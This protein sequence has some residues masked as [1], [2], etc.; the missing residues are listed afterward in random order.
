MFSSKRA[1]KYT[2]GLINTRNDC[3]A[4][5]SIQ[6]FASLPELTIYLNEIYR[7][8]SLI[9][10]LPLPHTDDDQN[11]VPRLR[12]HEALAK[13]VKQLQEP[14]KSKKYISVW[15]L[16]H[17]IEAIFNL[18]ISQNQNDAQE[19]VQLIVETLGNEHKKLK[20]Y[21]AKNALN[22]T[23]PDFPFDGLAADQLTCY[24][25]LNSSRPSFHPFSMLSLSVP[26]ETRATL[27]NMIRSNELQTINGYHCLRCKVK[28]IL[29]VEDE[30]MAKN[31][32]LD[33]EQSHIIS[34]LKILE[35]SLTINDDLEEPLNS[36]VKNYKFEGFATEN[37]LSTIVKKTL[38]IRPPSLLTI[39]LSRSV[40][41]SNHIQRNGC[42]VIFPDLLD[43]QELNARKGNPRYR[44]KAMVR[45]NGT[46]NAGH[47]ECYRHKPELVKDKET[48][49]VINRSPT[50]HW[51]EE[52]SQSAS[53]SQ[54]PSPVVQPKPH[55]GLQQAFN[56]SISRGS[57][58]GLDSDD[59]SH[60]SRF[61][62]RLGGL[63]SRRS[64]LSSSP[65]TTSRRNVSSTPTN[66]LDELCESTGSLGINHPP[67]S[68]CQQPQDP[69]SFKK[70]STV[71]KYPFWRISDSTVTEARKD[72]VLKENWAVYM[73]FY[74]IVR[75]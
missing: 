7:D 44:L 71:T 62:T 40:F 24:S 31:V 68:P 2:T 27:Y 14:I 8:Q 39:H 56:E 33:E 47:Y 53:S 3:F 48:G 43:I 38:I 34:R 72:D 45:Q 19:L 73:L 41:V 28:A 67:S 49:N 25:C 4:N 35:P 54:P 60:F 52:P 58:D 11:E 74:E 29:K 55:S 15:P 12:L 64:S 23:V 63:V 57:A 50:I 22:V 32:A 36:F 51:G 42:N 66:N 6:A 9:S 20:K 21:V 17:V 10:C 1:D 59:D 26:Q 30:K 13:I 65:S 69:T 46:H 75:D 5:S 70:I 16:L 18:K 61:K 37:L